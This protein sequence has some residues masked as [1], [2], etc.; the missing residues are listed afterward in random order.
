MRNHC[1]FLFLRVLRCFSSPRLP[2]RKR[3][4]RSLVSGC[5]IR[6]SPDQ[7]LFAPPRSL[8]Q[9]ITSFFAS[10]SQGIPHALL[11]TF[12][13]FL[14][15]FFF[16]SLQ[17]SHPCGRGLA[18]QAFFF[19]YVNELVFPFGNQ[20]LS[21]KRILNNLYIRT[22]MNLQ[23]PRRLDSE[24]LRCDEVSP[25]RRYSSHT[26]RYGYLVTT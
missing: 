5:P 2:P 16:F 8:S 19:Q 22:R 21:R 14:L 25:E 24:S 23:I 4:T 11:V 10:E 9:L 12:S 17:A 20:W 7:R 3:V 13:N 1:C 15:V 6:K 26:F 18:C